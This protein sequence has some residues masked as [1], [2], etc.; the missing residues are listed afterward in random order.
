MRKK[1]KDNSNYGEE[2]E[3]ILKVSLFLLLV[4][5]NIIH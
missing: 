1:R 2:N 4:Y 3:R 5:L